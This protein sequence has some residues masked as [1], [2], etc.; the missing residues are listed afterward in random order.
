MNVFYHV[1][2]IYVVLL[3]MAYVYR[4]ALIYKLHP[5]PLEGGL[6]ELQAMLRPGDVVYMASTHFPLDSIG[7]H[8]TA[9]ASVYMRQPFYHVFLV[10]PHQRVG[11]FVAPGYIPR[12]K[13]LC[14]HFEGGSLACYLRARQPYRPVYRIFRPP[15]EIDYEPILRQHMCAYRFDSFPRIAAG[16][17]FQWPDAPFRAHCNSYV[18]IMLQK[19]G[20]LPKHIPSYKF[21]PSAMMSTYLPM[22]GYRIIHDDVVWDG[23]IFST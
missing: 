15:Q 14:G 10:L 1:I 2:I 23:K 9:F 8:Y 13:T 12:M 18:G 22:A 4:K 19:M 5:R 7:H 21:I 11:H 17:L 20:K 6:D 16:I 3:L